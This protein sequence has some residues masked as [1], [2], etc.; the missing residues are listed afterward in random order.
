MEPWVRL[1]LGQVFRCRE[2]YKSVDIL[3]HHRSKGR[4]WVCNKS[5]SCG[6]QRGGSPPIVRI[7][8][9]LNPVTLHPISKGE[10]A[11]AD[12]IVGDIVNALW[13]NNYGIP[14]SQIKQEIAIGLI[15]GDLDN[16]RLYHGHVRNP[17]KQGFLGICAI[18][19]PRPIKAEFHVLS[20]HRGAIVKGDTSGKVEPV[21]QTILR[22]IP[23]LG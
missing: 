15:K 4:G 5:E 2:A 13:G 14:P 22:D 1:K 11:G 17:L 10:R 8:G 20:I 21:N 23:A 7:A 9:Q 18:L 6:F 16:Q 3:S 19:G 12:G